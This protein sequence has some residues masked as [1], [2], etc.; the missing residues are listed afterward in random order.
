MPL[1]VNLLSA[2]P[3]SEVTEFAAAALGNLAA[4]RQVFKDAIREVSPTSFTK[5]FLF[6]YCILRITDITA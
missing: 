5:G 2:G 4:G 3:E 1:L 6:K